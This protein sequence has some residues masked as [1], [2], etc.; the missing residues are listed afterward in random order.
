MAASGTRRTVLEPRRGF[1]T[2]WHTLRVLVRVLA[3]SAVLAA[4]TLVPAAT[5]QSPASAKA[6]AAVV[7][8]TLGTVA[9]VKA[10]GDDSESRSAPSKTPDGIQLNNGL[11]SVETTTAGGDASATAQAEADQI[12]LLDGV[13]SA[14]LVLRTADDTGSGVKYHGTV[15]GLKIGDR[16]IDE[17]S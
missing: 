15:R 10:S 4:G 5:A 3:A 11:V 14:T 8:G 9:K 16:T 13:I 12:E 17:V 6:T 2:V 7:T 1:G